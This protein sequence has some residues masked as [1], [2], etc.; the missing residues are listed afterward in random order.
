MCGINGIVLL[1]K[2]SDFRLRDGYIAQLDT[3]NDSIAHRGPDSVGTFVKEPIAF[4]FRRLSIIDLS[5]AAD[6][7]ME[8]A[9]GEIILTILY[10][11]SLFIKV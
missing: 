7:P 2:R 10:L 4:G 8:S 3:M 1:G 9:D 6:Q 11:L 5:E